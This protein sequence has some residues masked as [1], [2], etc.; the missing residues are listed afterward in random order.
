M[1]QKKY[2]SKIMVSSSVDGF[3]NDLNLLC[4][5]LTRMGY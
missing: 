3:E 5:L 2:K 1:K 4:A